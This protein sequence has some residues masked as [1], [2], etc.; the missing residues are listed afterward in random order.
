MKNILNKTI[1]VIIDKK[2][3]SRDK[4]KG[5]YYASNYGKLAEDETV[6]AYILGEYRPLES[7]RGKV[8]GVIERE[9]MLG[10]VVVVTNPENTYT[11]KQISAL[12]E[13]KER[14]YKS[15]LYTAGD[16]LNKEIK[17]K[18]LGLVYRN[19]EILVEKYYDIT[20]DETFYRFLGG[21]ID[22]HEK[23]EIALAR[24]F[25]EEINATI[26]IVS[27]KVTLE[28]IFK[29]G[30]SDEHEVVS[31]YEI[32]IDD[33]FYELDTFLKMENKTESDV[34]WIDKKKFID[35]KLILY[36]KKIV[37]YI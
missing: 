2:I 28:N 21:G 4:N 16:F 13:F 17:F 15:T 7:F 24:E 5:F 32:Q 14:F 11:F 10:S 23:A 20:K 18:A 27:H 30:N 19:N 29:F 9:G 31:V 37:E 36:P 8:V 33:H 12:I 1:D 3:G 34:Y 22:F 35:K 6:G 25:K 26:K